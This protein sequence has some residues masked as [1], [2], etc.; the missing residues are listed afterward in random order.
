MGEIMWRWSKLKQVIVIMI[1]AV[2]P[3]NEWEKLQKCSDLLPAASPNPAPA[4]DVPGV[5]SYVNAEQHLM[6]VAPKIS[7]ITC[8]VL[9]VFL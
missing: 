6:V 8:E 2:W 4:V 1:V 9:T 5:S 3:T 7:K